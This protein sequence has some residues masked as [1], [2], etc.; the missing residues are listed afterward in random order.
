MSELTDEELNKAIHG[1]RGL[2]WHETKVYANC[3]GWKCTKCREICIVEN[4][5]DYTSSRDACAVVEEELSYEQ[6]VLYIDNLSKHCCSTTKKESND[7]LEAV[8]AEKQCEVDI[9]EKGRLMGQYDR[10]S[11]ATA[12][13][14]KRAEALL[15][16]LKEK[17]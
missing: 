5:P 13:P 7:Y 2:C 8:F 17:K 3:S 4:N 16:V 14:R 9:N 6:R 15:E 10:Y 1:A 11:F 12:P